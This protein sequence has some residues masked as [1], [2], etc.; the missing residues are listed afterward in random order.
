MHVYGEMVDI[1]AEQGRFDAAHELELLWNELAARKSL[2]LLCGYASVR[3]GDVRDAAALH[4]ICAHT[5]VH[6]DAGDLL[7]TWLLNDRQSRYHT[8][9][10]AR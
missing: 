3:F 2:T 10:V 8:R 5:A 4:R 6:A 1:L 9:W 7:G